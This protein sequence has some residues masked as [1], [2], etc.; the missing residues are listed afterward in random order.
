MVYDFGYRLKEL[1]EKKKLSQLQVAKRLDITRAS[2]S[3]YE[4]NIATP[5]VDVLIKLALLYRVSTDYLLGI[6]NRRVIV[7]DNLTPRQQAVVETIMDT[8]IAEFQTRQQTKSAN[9]FCLLN[10]DINTLLGLF[11]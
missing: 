5:S 2:V 10:Y 1:R 4:N 8:L 3:S 6:D 11:Y 7:I 9:S